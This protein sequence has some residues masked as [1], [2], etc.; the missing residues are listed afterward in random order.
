MGGVLAFFLC[1]T[2]LP[3]RLLEFGGFGATLLDI[4]VLPLER[5]RHEQLSGWVSAD[6]VGDSTPVLLFVVDATW[7]VV[8]AGLFNGRAGL[9]SRRTSKLDLTEDSLLTLHIVL[10]KYFTCHYDGYEVLR[11]SCFSL[12]TR[13]Y[14]ALRQRWLRAGGVRIDWGRV[15]D[16]NG[17]HL[18]LS[19]LVSLFR[20]TFT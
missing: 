1:V 3:M 4:R 16:V 19:T 10:Q 17:D 12:E 5:E 2:Y 6:N 9:R 15:G 7:R 8:H 20:S 18:E 14:L 11:A 13:P